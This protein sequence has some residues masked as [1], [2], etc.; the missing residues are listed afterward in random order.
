MTKNCPLCDKQFKKEYILY[1]DDN[2]LVRHSEETNILG[3]FILQ[4]KDHLID[5]SEANDSASREYGVVLNR[6]MKAIRKITD[7]HRIYTFSL[8]EAVPH[9]HLHVIPKAETFPRTYTGR[10]ITSYPVK[11]VCPHEL[12]IEAIERASKQFKVASLI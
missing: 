11:P 8:G 10:G 5:L 7:C 12:V 2:W 3:Y 4:S 6:L 9:Y 1:E